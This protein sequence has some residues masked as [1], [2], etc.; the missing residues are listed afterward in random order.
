ML[1]LLDLHSEVM[2]SGMGENL[3]PAVK[4]LQANFLQQLKVEHDKDVQKWEAEL[5]KHKNC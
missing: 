5:V 3:K 1:D 4:Q 2:E